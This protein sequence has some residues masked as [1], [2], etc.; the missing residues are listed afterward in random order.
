MLVAWNTAL[1]P[2]FNSMAFKLEESGHQIK[3]GVNRA[4]GS[5]AYSALCA[6]LGT[7]TERM[8]VQVLPVTDGIVLILLILTLVMTGKHFKKAWLHKTAGR[9]GKR[10][11]N[12][13]LPDRA[14]TFMSCL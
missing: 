4:V 1:Q 13:G 2:L 7:L 14:R 6:V 3:F 9:K 11:Q 8:G 12:H 5:L 10:R